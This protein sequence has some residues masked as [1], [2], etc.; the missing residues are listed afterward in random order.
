MEGSGNV[1]GRLLTA[2]ADGAS[3]HHAADE[4]L[5]ITAVPRPGRASRTR[6][7]KA[8]PTVAGARIPR[9]H[10][11]LRCL[12]PA[13][14]VVV[15]PVSLLGNITARSRAF[16]DRRDTAPT[17]YPSKAGSGSRR[18]PR[19][20]SE[21][22]SVLCAALDWAP[23]LSG[24]YER[25]PE[26]QSHQ[27]RPPAGWINY[28][29]PPRIATARPTESLELSVSRRYGTDLYELVVLHLEQEAGEVS[30]H[31]SLEEAQRF[32]FER[33][34]V[35]GIDWTIT[36]A[37]RLTLRP[38]MGAESPLWNTNGEMVPLEDFPA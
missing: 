16:S 1:S 28:R 8:P 5:K 25:M 18:R 13:L 35:A 33:T 21:G 37:E 2:R 29:P 32:A 20:L 9:Q 17:G 27:S 22:R 23:T 36:G 30:R 12:L 24:Q 7:R 19:K 34:G 31:D 38:E 26:D 14:A 15:Q 3:S 6:S 4:A 11:G 10:T